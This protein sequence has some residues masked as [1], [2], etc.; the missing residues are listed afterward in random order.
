[1]VPRLG[2][3]TGSAG[4]ELKGRRVVAYA[5]YSTDR[6][7]PR[8]I[9]D[10]VRVCREFIERN[11][12]KLADHLV[13]SD[14]AI[15]GTSTIR[16]GFQALFEAVRTGAVDVVITEDLSRIG[17]DVGN[18]DRILKSFRTWGAR[19]LAINDGIDTGQPHA[20]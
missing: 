1:A 8:S 3:A 9:D 14:A 5:R 20:K 4:M 15:S 17:R 7:N 10:Q 11:G 16:P 6:Q 19:L 13:F 2:A 12:G 18:N